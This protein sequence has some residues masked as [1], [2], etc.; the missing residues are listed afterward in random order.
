LPDV[1]RI[2][3]L[4]DHYPDQNP[5]REVFASRSED[6]WS[7]ASLK[8]Y[9][10][11]VH[12]LARALMYRLDQGD[13]IATV[14]NNRPE[15]NFVDMAAA[16]SG[17][18]HV[19]IYPTICLEEF[20]YILVHAG[21]KIL[22][23]SDR[24]LYKLLAPLVDEINDMQGIYC[25]E[26]YADLPCFRD[27]ILERKKLVSAERLSVRAE[28]VKPDHLFTLIY[29][30]GTTGQPKGVM[31]SHY[32]ILSN[33]KAVLEF[34]P[35]ENGDRALSILPLCHITERL[36]NYLYQYSGIK[37]FYARNFNTVLSD[38]QDSRA[39]GF[40]AVPRV[41]EKILE[42]IQENAR[43]LKPQQRWVFNWAIFQA[44]KYDGFPSRRQLNRLL[45]IDRR[46]FIHWR[47]ALGGPKKFVACGAAF[48]DPRILRIFL[49]A[50]FPIHEGYGMTEAS[51]I[52]SINHFAEP[53]NFRIGTHGPP[54][55]NMGVKIAEDGEILINGPNIMMGYFREPELTQQAFTQDGWFKT[56]DTGILEDGFLT[57][58]GRKKELFKTSGGKY[59]APLAIERIFVQSRLIDN[60]MVVGDN[61]KFPGAIILPNFEFLADWARNQKIKYHK[62]ADLVKIP[63]VLKFFEKEISRLNKTLGKTEQIKDFRLV[64]DEWSVPTGELSPTLKIR[65]KVVANKY[66]K[67]TRSIYRPPKKRTPPRKSRNQ[68][69]NKQ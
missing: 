17:T 3:D 52:V 15:W 22:F 10:K 35:M 12:Y 11:N 47:K 2:F 44:E 50:G 45:R 27:L 53:G 7:Y 68:K 4:L 69:K 13:R 64:G 9:K 37:I 51:P 33:M 16:M 26:Q 66:E 63:K 19:P 61:Q 67:L 46:V 39:Q 5:E 42:K 28:S 56:G 18:V 36:V 65:R 55:K 57:I 8:D 40:V 14:S 49:A 38:L 25:F 34:F 60:I 23:V 6:A 41:L 58:T 29:T 54:L 1:R 30:S 21:V 31:L 48:L 32:N 20:R 59:I 24:D 62:P 43:K